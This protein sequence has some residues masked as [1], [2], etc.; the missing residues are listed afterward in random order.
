MVSK[1]NSFLKTYGKVLALFLSMLAGGLMPQAHELASLIRYFVM[2][3][4]FFAFLDTKFNP[5][6]FQKSVLWI[7]VANIVIAFLA[8]GERQ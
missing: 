5:R 4:L 1:T 8:Y 6:S 2:A 7:L 3:M